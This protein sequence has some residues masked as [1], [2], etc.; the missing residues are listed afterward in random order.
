[1]FEILP[2]HF[3]TVNRNHYGTE[4]VSPQRMIKN[5]KFYNYSKLLFKISF[6]S[7]SNAGMK[8]SGSSHTF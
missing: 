6:S 5:D 8:S 2:K 1:M 7:N 4:F 3:K